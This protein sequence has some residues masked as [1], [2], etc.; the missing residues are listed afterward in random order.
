MK[1]YEYL[2]LKTDDLKIAVGTYQAKLENNTLILPNELESILVQYRIKT[3]LSALSWIF[4][5]PTAVAHNLDWD[6]KDVVK[7]NEELKLL[8]DWQDPK[9]KV[10]FGAR[11]PATYIN[12]K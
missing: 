7:A 5:Y 12:Q 8:L 1:T 9:I 11:N 6:V 3:V 2:T 10:S 4:C